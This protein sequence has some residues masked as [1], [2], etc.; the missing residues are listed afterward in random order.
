MR[1]NILL[2]AILGLASFAVTA[3]SE[4]KVDFEKQIWPIFKKSCVKCHQPEHKD[5]RGRSRRP[6]AHLVMTNKAGIIKGGEDNDD[7]PALT[8]GDPKKS[9][10]LQ[11][12]LL[13]LDEDEHMPPEDKAPQLT[14]EQK[15]LLEKWIAEG[16]DFGKW[17]RDPEVDH[18]AEKK[19]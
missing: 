10:Y 6:K 12:T 13:G 4:D 8:P 17:E 16:A 11:A 3:K 7:N 2:V 19:E 1:N 15:K 9:A 5:E 18:Q 14:D